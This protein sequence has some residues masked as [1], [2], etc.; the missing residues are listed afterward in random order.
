MRLSDEHHAGRRG[1]NYGEI[2]GGLALARSDPP[3][4][5]RTKTIV[6]VPT[7]ETPPVIFWISLETRGLHHFFSQS[8]VTSSSIILLLCLATLKKRCAECRRC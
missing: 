8:V 5:T 1:K 6:E 3:H 4:L 2:E 7:R